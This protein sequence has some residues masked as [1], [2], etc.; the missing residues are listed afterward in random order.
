M[1]KKV[2]LFAMI[3]GI[4]AIS[5]SC[6]F[7]VITGNGSLVTS[8]KTVSTFEKIK[9]SSS[10][11]VRFHASQEYRVVITVDENLNEYVEIE[12]ENNV[13]SIGTKSGSYSFTKF[14]VDVYCPVLTGVSMSGS[15][16]FENTDKITVSSFESAVSGSGKINVTVECESFSATISGSGRINS[17]GNSKDANIVISGSGQFNGN[18]F[19]INNATVRVSGS[20]NM[21]ISVTDNLKA[22]ISGSGGI[23]Y[24]GEPKIDSNVS[25][26]GRIR[27]M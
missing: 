4:F 22:N 24:R 1:S 27:K 11:A 8:E 10:A 18:D 23:T 7:N 13:L 14:S 5:V 15:G 12:A 17:T 19:T 2:I 6:A 25:G 26:S 16:N 9:V 21:N 3:I 20:G